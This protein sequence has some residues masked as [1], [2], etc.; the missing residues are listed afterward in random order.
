MPY[1]EPS[2]DS[3]H[4]NV[5]LTNVS[6]AYMQQDAAF[7]APR[8]F[9][10]VAVAN[11]SNAYFVYDRGDFNRVEM[12]VRAPS[13]ESAGGGFRLSRETYNA[14]VR[15][16]HKDIDEQSRGNQDSVLDLEMS[17]VRYVT[18]QGMLEREIN[19]TS[20]YFK[21]G[22]WTFEADGASTRSASFDPTDATVNDL[23]QWDDA[24]STPIEDVR[25]LK[26]HILEETG[27]M[28]NTLTLGRPVFDTLVDHPDIVGRL[29]RGQTT[30]PVMATKDSLAALFEL[31]TILVMDGIRN[32]A[33]EGQTA[34]HS[35]I[36]GKHALLSYRPATPGLM[37]PS[38]GYSFVWTGYLGSVAGGI[39][40]TRF[41]DRKIRSTRIEA[42]MAYDH[43][44]ISADL[45]AFFNDIVA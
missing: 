10:L 29:D 13:T 45:G 1:I 36:G 15:A 14:E 2:V 4:V 8:V 42:E 37:E 25:L 39:E 16:V 22:V 11:K 43:K 20:K 27:Y 21:T 33:A 7:V 19:W 24:N 30:G 34:S 9:P 44:V 38:A 23:A 6:V 5:P 17:A 28:P 3:V 31:D 40:I 18:R 32:T 12:E 35:F 26:R 41:Y